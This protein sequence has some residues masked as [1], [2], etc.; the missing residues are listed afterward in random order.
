L[1]GQKRTDSISLKSTRGGLDP[2]F[3]DDPASRN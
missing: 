3:V 1:S 2:A